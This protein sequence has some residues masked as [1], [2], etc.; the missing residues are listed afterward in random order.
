MNDH[1]S[2]QDEKGELH[3]FTSPKSWNELTEKQLIQWAGICLQTLSL[4]YVLR[5][6]LILFC[7]IPEKLFFKLRDDQLTLIRPR[8]EFLFG[9]NKLTKWVISQFTFRGVQ[10]YGPVDYLGNIKIK[11]FRRTEIYYQKYLATKDIQYV[12]LLAATLYRPLRK[13]VIDD[14]KREDL[15]EHSVFTRADL[16]KGHRLGRFRFNYL[17]PAFLH[18]ILLNY[19]GC[20]ISIHDQFPKVF[21]K[22][23]G[24]KASNKVFDL[25][26]LIDSVAG[27][28]MGDTLATENI[29][30]YRFFKYLTKQIESAE[31]IKQR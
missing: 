14:D 23:E 1:F 15:N 12:R 30:M 31:K 26:E 13:G 16:F 8:I 18:A 11:E 3:R 20:R 22:R 6:A 27:G 7:A 5:C 10:Y 21:V 4:D 9:K 17:K 28:A 24:V 19:E 2:I 25:E 29:N